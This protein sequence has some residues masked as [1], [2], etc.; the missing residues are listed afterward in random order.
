MKIWGVF[1]ANV[2]L[3][4][5]RNFQVLSWKL[6]KLISKFFQGFFLAIFQL[7]K[8]WNVQVFS[9]TFVR[10]FSQKDFQQ[11]F[12][13]SSSEMFLFLFFFLENSWRESQNFR[14]IYNDSNTPSFPG[15]EN[16]MALHQQPPTSLCILKIL[17]HFVSHADISHT[18]PPPRSKTFSA[19]RPLLDPDVSASG[20][21]SNTRPGELRLKSWNL[22]N[23]VLV[24]SCQGEW[25]HKS[26]KSPSVRPD[27]AHTRQIRLS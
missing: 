22:C 3:F 5:R 20:R 23:L 26:S 19:W 14:G 1:Q 7:F 16:F 9:K 15:P 27:A 18:L 8:L 21:Q 10:I 17:I 2:Q 11:T 24:R 4:K 12:D 25:Q 6:L 13:V